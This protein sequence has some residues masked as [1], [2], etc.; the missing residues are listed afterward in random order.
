M[1]RVRTAHCGAFDLG[2]ALDL[3]LG[4]FGVDGGGGEGQGGDEVV[5]RFH[6][7]SSFRIVAL[8]LRVK[9]KCDGS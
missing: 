1:L 9:P 5:E 7:G 4:A 8:K 2:V 6:V 3:A